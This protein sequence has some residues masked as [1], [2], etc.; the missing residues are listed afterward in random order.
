MSLMI[1]TLFSTFSIYL[2]V[3]FIPLPSVVHANETVKFICRKAAS[4]DISA[5]TTI[6]VTNDGEHSLITWDTESFPGFPPQ[7]RCQD[8]THRFQQ[9][10]DNNALK[11]LTNGQINKQPVLCAVKKYGDQC[12]NDNLLMTLLATE[13]SF[14][15]LNKLRIML[16]AWQY[17]PIKHSGGIPQV[18][19]QID[20]DSFPRAKSQ[21]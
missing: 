4:G 17:G 16:G 5:W 3:G 7:M 20:F 12:K 6:A 18:Y 14:K 8:V 9:A 13:D 1:R 15:V 19:Y 2:L 11:L 21:S 10:Y